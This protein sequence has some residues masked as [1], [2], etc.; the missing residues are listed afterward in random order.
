[1]LFNSRAFARSCVLGFLAAVSLPAVAHAGLIWS[2]EFNGTSPSSAWTKSKFWWNGDGY[3]NA[4][5]VYRDNALS[6]SGGA[7]AL[8]LRRENATSFQGTPV[9]YVSGLVQTGGIRNRAAPGFSFRFGYAEARIK[10]PKGQGVWPAFW[11]LPASYNDDAGEIDIME[12]KGSEA[13]KIYSFVHTNG[14]SD[15]GA[16]TAPLDMSQDWHTYGVDWRPD[17]LN[18]YVDGILRRTIAN[19][20]LIPQEASYLILNLQTGGGWVGLPDATTQ[21][22]ATMQV[23]YVRVWTSV[24]EPTAAAALVPVLAACSMRRRRIT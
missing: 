6:V 3:N 9:Q 8:T 16:W 13:N 19:P 15:G 20:A 21:L 24:P 7:L 1:M 12:Y 18:F 11:M 14:Q 5:H 4:S 2:D 10:M 22:P 23:D 17:S